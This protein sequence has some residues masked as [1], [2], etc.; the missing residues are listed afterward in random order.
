M[1]CNYKI[2]LYI[3]LY[4]CLYKYYIYILNT[5]GAV[6]DTRVCYRFQYHLAILKEKGLQ[7]YEKYSV[8]NK[9][10]WYISRSYETTSILVNDK[11]FDSWQSP[12]LEAKSG[13]CCKTLPAIEVLN[14]C[15]LSVREK[16]RD[17]IKECLTTCLHIKLCR[18][19]IW[20]VLMCKVCYDLRKTGAFSV[21]TWW[22]CLFQR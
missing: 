19:N 9:H 5:R 8:N 4:F 2:K 1:L 18:K 10:V 3:L 11:L 7:L 17:V 20:L 12:V 22:T 13:C 6:D 21:W 16:V 14:S 15:D